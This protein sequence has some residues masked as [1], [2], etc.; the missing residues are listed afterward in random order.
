LTIFGETG[1]EPLRE[2]FRRHAWLTANDDLQSLLAHQRRAIERRPDRRVH[3]REPEALR[4]D[5]DDGVRLV[6][7]PDGAAD[8]VRP[9]VEEKQPHPVAEDRRSWIDRF[10]K[11]PAGDGIHTKEREQVRCHRTDPDR[12]VAVIGADL[13]RFLFRRRG[14]GGE[15]TLDRVPPDRE[16]RARHGTPQRHDRPLSRADLD[17]RQLLG[18]PIEDRRLVE[19]DVAN[20]Q[21]GRRRADSAAQRDDGDQ[22]GNWITS[23]S[24][25]GTAEVLSQ[26]VHRHAALDTGSGKLVSW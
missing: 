22:G 19:D 7:D 8:D 11:R 17:G 15:R 23:D 24:A 9:S 12:I 26:V 14:Q 18:I 1:L 21:R 13:P 3:R 10:G 6:L 5:A 20:D 16:Q 2:L 4:H 25:D